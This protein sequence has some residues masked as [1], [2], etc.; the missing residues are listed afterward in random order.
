MEQ[1]S[2]PHSWEYVTTRKVLWRTTEERKLAFR[3]A[4][5][6]YCARKRAFALG[7]PL[8]AYV[9]SS[10]SDLD[11]VYGDGAVVYKVHDSIEFLDLRV[12]GRRASVPLEGLSNLIRR[13]R[14]LRKCELVWLREEIVI[15]NIFVEHDT[16]GLD[17]SFLLAIDFSDPTSPRPCMVSVP[18][19]QI[20]M[21]WV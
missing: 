8:A 18:S 13:A 19:D 11:F 9:L 7:S 3:E 10:G 20:K 4:F 1:N 14:R 2:A 21:L 6:R 17:K 5:R 15:L 12:T 16:V